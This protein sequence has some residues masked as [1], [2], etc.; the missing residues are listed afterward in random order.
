M[1]APR[2]WRPRSRTGVIEDGVARAG[3]TS[4]SSL[5]PRVDLPHG[6]R[7]AGAGG[8]RGDVG[9]R[10]QERAAVL[11]ERAAGLRL[12]LP[13][14]DHHRVAAGAVDEIERAG[15]AGLGLQRG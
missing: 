13:Q 9:E 6:D 4:T 14:D 7:A 5:R 2:W 12:A 10:L 8:D 3:P 1:I 15:E 11:G